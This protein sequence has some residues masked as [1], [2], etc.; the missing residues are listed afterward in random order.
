MNLDTVRYSRQ[1]IRCVRQGVYRAKRYR[2]VPNLVNVHSWT[3]VA[4]NPF[5][6]VD[7]HSIN[8]N[9]GVTLLSQN[10][11]SSTEAFASYGWNRQRRGDCSI[12]ACAISGWASVSTSTPRTAATRFS[13]RWDSTTSR[14]ANP[15]T[16]SVPAP[17]KYYSVGL[18]ATLPLYF[19]RGYHTRQLSVSAGW[20]YSNGM[21]ADLG[22]IEWN[23]RTASPTSS[24]SVS[25]RDC[26]SSRSDWGTRI[27]CAWRTATSRRAGAIR[28]STAYYLQPGQHPFQRPDFVLRTGI[29]ARIRGPQLAEG[30][31]DLPDLDRRLQVPVG[32]RAAELSARRG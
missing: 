21:V 10:L 16:S 3:P 27:R 19:Q 18:S 2:K 15:S 6:A 17:D 1:P 29:P 23:A 24:A 25:A 12:W 31:R 32:I 13:I 30:R 14:R 7:E 11:L 4:F 20:N 28:L 5:E 9:V 26:T 22:K 8:L